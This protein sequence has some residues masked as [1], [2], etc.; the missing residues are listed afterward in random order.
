MQSNKRRFNRRRF[1][2]LT[3]AAGLGSLMAGCNLPALRSGLGATGLAGSE[4]GLAPID[5][6]P[7]EGTALPTNFPTPDLTLVPTG[8]STVEAGLVSTSFDLPYSIDFSGLADGPLP[9]WFTGA[10]WR[11]AAGL[12]VNTPT[13]GVELLNDPGLEA[14][15]SNESRCISLTAVENP[16]LKQSDDSHGGKSS[17][18]FQGTVID[19]AVY[20]TPLIG[21]S[22]EWYQLSI[23]AKRIAGEGDAARMSLSQTG[24]IPAAHAEWAITSPDYQLGKVS[25][26]STSALDLI[27]YAVKQGQPVDPNTVIV[28]DD[29][30]LKKIT[31]AS[32]YGLFPATQAD[33]VIK[34]KPDE[35]VDNTPIGIV[36]R[37]NAAA[38][39]V[40]Y[41]LILLTVREERPA[42]SVLNVIK[43]DGSSYKSLVTNTLVGER[44]S[45]A[46]FEVR[47]EGQAISIWYNQ[48]KIG[49]DLTGEDVEISP[50]NYHGLFSAGDNRLKALYLA[51]KLI[52]R[53]QVYGGS[54]FTASN[55]YRLDV[56]AF[57]KSK[58]P[59]YEYIFP[60]LAA[61][62]HNTWSNLVRLNSGGDVF[63]LDHA[64][65]Q[66]AEFVE[67][68]IL[69]LWTENPATQIILITSPSWYT[70]DT[71]DDS[72]VYSPANLAVVQ[73]VMALAA[74]YGIT[75]VDYWTWCIAAINQHQ[76][77]LNELT[78]DTIHPSK[79]GY[80]GMAKLVEQFLPDGGTAKPV[81]LPER[82]F[83]QSSLFQAR[84]VRITGTSYTARTGSG[85][86]DD[87][88]TISSS[89]PGDTVTYMTTDLWCSF[90]DWR[91]DYQPNVVE[92][93]L[94]EGSFESLPFE[95]NGYVMYSAI[96]NTITI[97]I[98][99]GGGNVKIE[100][101]WLI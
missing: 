8:A 51:D 27:P 93:S 2:I 54:S 43:A 23:W 61:G 56:N 63:I 47:A 88:T 76:Y 74:H 65:D 6:I 96:Y 72:Q 16:V 57:C 100:E 59:Q 17:Q 29:G 35:P 26:L 62:R 24:G 92:I 82:V 81:V 37:A 49:N 84:P 7:P 98:P 19:S 86:V 77:H 79:V 18:Q 38:D 52:P 39:P 73:A 75:L 97:R 1:L 14:R 40:S 34:I 45:D 48:V 95:Q 33:I 89:T 94:N 80:A 69:R 70:R 58:F 60:V 22:G 101:V 66:T 44:V 4:T 55:G 91:S 32:L 31:R 90:G 64:N 78:E 12:L 25:L 67:A 85:W 99:D 41:F 68:M 11:I 30:S 3:G 53:V 50:N 9:D 20:W 83:K 21:E 5:R 46:W 42:E 87:G 28:V 13:L 36:L 10:T 71:G 15:Y